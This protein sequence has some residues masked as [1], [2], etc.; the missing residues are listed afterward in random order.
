MKK[1]TNY[2]KLYGITVIQAKQISKSILGRYPRPGY[3]LPIEKGVDSLG[4]EYVIF[5]ENCAGSFSIRKWT[6]AA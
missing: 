4:R 3:E 5:L 6:S 2:K 1:R